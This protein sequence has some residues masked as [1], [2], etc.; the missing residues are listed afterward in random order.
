MYNVHDA[1]MLTAVQQYSTLQIH[2]WQTQ[3][4]MNDGQTPTRTPTGHRHAT[5]EIEA[6]DSASKIARMFLKVCAFACQPSKR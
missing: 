1:N 6:R 4:Y 3:L 2:N 5:I